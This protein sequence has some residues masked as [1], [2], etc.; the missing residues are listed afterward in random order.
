M[1]K[2]FENWRKFSKLT[3]GTQWTKY[4]RITDMLKGDVAS[5]D[6]IS[7][8]TP[9]N[10]HAK[11]TPNV[12]SKRTG[13]FLELI[14]QAGYGFRQID[15]MYGGKEVSYVVPHLS[16][17]EAARYSY[18]FGQESFVYSVRQE[19]DEPILHQLIM[20]DGYESAEQDPQYDIEEY[21]AIYSVPTSVQ[22]HVDV[23]TNDLVE[24][25]DLVGEKD[26]YSNV[27][28]KNYIDDKTGEAVHKP[29]PRFKMDFYP[30]EPKDAVVTKPTKP[31][32]SSPRYMRETFIHINSTE[33]PNT[34]KAKKLAENIHK[35][36][37]FIAEKD[38]T[39]SSKYHHRKM[40]I[41][42]KKELKQIMEEK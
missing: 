41:K 14:S 16:K 18:M 36:S 20:I 34:Q 26:F 15:G 9:E 11:P 21:G 37:I 31:P 32:G 35:R 23:E 7:V 25:G 4:R 27:P 19:G 33:V 24:F 22:T 42:E 40:I 10:P 12:N 28:D 30:D 6:E 13:L 38:R 5:V 3:E 8:L 1:K 2:L 29:G 17:E 39:G